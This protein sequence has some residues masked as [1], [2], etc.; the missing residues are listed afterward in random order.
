MVHHRDDDDDK[1]GFSVRTRK[2]PFLPFQQV[3]YGADLGIE[4][5]SKMFTLD[6]R[7]LNIS[8]YRRLPR[9]MLWLYNIIVSSR[10]PA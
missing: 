1:K 6:E 7:F 10:K 3:H 9:E 5:Y 4:D 8:Q 2:C